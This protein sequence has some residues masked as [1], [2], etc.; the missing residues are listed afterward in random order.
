MEKCLVFGRFTVMWCDFHKKA[1]FN[2]KVQFLRFYVSSTN[3]NIT[4]NNIV[5]FINFTDHKINVSGRPAVFTRQQ[6]DNHQ[7]GAQTVTK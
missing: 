6:T 1:C 5:D 7:N 3:K 4:S 2:E